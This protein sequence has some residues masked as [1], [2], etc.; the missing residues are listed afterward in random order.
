MPLPTYVISKSALRQA[1]FTYTRTGWLE[2]NGPPEKYIGKYAKQR[3][4]QYAFQQAF[5]CGWLAAKG[6]R[7][8][9]GPNGATFS[10]V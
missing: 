4:L 5:G 7:L 10:F 1:W 6:Y 3:E 2:D 8:E 9:F